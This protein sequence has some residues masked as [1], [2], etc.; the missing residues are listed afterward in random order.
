MSGVLYWVG[1]TLASFAASVFISGKWTINRQR[2]WAMQAVS[3]AQQCP[4][5]GCLCGPEVDQQLP[6][7]VRL[8]QCARGHHWYVVPLH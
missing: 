8:C 1:M 6:E 3:Q 2:A 5:P 7:G 4:E